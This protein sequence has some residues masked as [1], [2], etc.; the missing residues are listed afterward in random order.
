MGDA[1]SGRGSGRAR[2]QGPKPERPFT[3][4]GQA[5]KGRRIGGPVHE[6]PAKSSRA[7]T[8]GT[9]SMSGVPCRKERDLWSYASTCCGRLRGS[10]SSSMLAVRRLYITKD[11][12]P[13]HRPT[14][15]GASTPP[16][17][18]EAAYYIEGTCAPVSGVVPARV[19]A[20][21]DEAIT[22]GC[23]VGHVSIRERA[24]DTPLCCC[25]S[26]RWHGCAL[27]FMVATFRRKQ[28]PRFCHCVRRLPCAINSFHFQAF[29]CVAPV[30]SVARPSPV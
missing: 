25:E 15:Y 13:I 3:V 11:G 24:A 19:G 28:F 12:S 8:H 16:P 30:S 29:Y 23:R 14:L 20:Q 27:G 4:F 6:K 1:K 26:W 10:I 9:D 17:T 18:Q 7:S 2:S 22:R 5:A 21:T